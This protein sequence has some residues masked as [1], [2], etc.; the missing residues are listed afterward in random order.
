MESVV[1]SPA[2]KLLTILEMI[3]FEHTLF[4]LLCA[5]RGCCR[6]PRPAEAEHAAVDSGCDDRGKGR[7]D[8]F[9]RSQIC[10][11]DALNPRDLRAYS[12]QGRPKYTHKNK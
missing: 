4:A 6:R 7:G 5:D 3:K 12:T 9:N 10:T 2:R 8:G 11:V 1:K